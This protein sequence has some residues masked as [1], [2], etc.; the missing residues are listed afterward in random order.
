MPHQAD[1]GTGDASKNEIECGEA[2]FYCCTGTLLNF[3]VDCGQYM[4]MYVY[5]VRIQYR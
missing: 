1:L 3:F 2:V 5:K 4:C